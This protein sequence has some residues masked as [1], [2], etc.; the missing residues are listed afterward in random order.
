MDLDRADTGL[1]TGAIDAQDNPLPTVKAA[2]FYEVTDQIVM[3]DHLVDGIFLS[4][5]MKT[6]EKLSE[7]QQQKVL[8]AARKATAYNNE[9]RI[10]DEKQLVKFFEDQGLKVY[11]PDVEAFRRHVQDAYKNS[12]FAADW[13]DGIVEK[14][15]AV[16]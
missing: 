8:A 3:T 13:E 12:K 10:Q 4:M 6:R 5:A 11:K 7:E 16:K 9:K 15:N 2:K 1:Q 14:I